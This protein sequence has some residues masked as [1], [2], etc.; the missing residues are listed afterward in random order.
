MKK[1]YFTPELVP[2]IN[3]IWSCTGQ[4]G[5][6]LK[7]LVNEKE[8]PNCEQIDAG[9]FKQLSSRGKVFDTTE[10]YVS[11]EEIIV[12]KEINGQW[13]GEMIDLAAIWPE[14]QLVVGLNPETKQVMRF[15]PVFVVYDAETGLL[16]KDNENF[17]VFVEGIKSYLPYA[18]LILRD[19]AKRRVNMF[20]QKTLNLVWWL[21]E[22]C[23]VA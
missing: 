18:R 5:W 17:R 4:E 2:S 7:D 13:N 3:G 16:T 10:L 20:A 14:H 1:N 23:A 19:E 9:R 8:I 22:H 6:Y 11:A 21:K 12:Q 15:A